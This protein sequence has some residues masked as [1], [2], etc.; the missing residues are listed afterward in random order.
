MINYYEHNTIG[1][2]NQNDDMI[3]DYEYDV[4]GEF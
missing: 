4:V 2:F 1:V 3:N